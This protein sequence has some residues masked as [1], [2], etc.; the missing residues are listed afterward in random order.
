MIRS[1]FSIQV[2]ILSL[3]AHLPDELLSSEYIASSLNSNP[4]LVR[5]ELSV[6][7]EAG[8]VESKEGK[9]GGSQLARSPKDIRMSDVFTLVKNGHVFGFAPN[10]PNP[11]CTVGARINGALDELFGEIDN[12]IFDK[13]KSITLAEFTKKYF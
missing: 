2:H 7:R 12:S 4:A 10:E 1:K 5:K 13:L 6:L 9:N 3:L 8:L 11:K